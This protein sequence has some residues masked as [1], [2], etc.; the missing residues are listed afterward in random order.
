MPGT[1]ERFY[2]GYIRRMKP[3]SIVDSRVFSGV[4]LWSRNRLASNWYSMIDA[5]SNADAEIPLALYF[6]RM[7]ESMSALLQLL[8]GPENAAY[9]AFLSHFNISVGLW[10]S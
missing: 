5:G 6:C 4:A 7:F 9:T 3:L 2:C 1:P 10:C 8:G